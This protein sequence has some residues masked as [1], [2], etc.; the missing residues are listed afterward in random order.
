MADHTI[1]IQSEG[2]G[3]PD[4]K[5]SGDSLTFSESSKLLAEEIRNLLKEMQKADPKATYA[6]AQKQFHQDLRSSSDTRNARNAGRPDV[7]A[8]QTGRG[9]TEDYNLLPVEGGRPQSPEA[10]EALNY[11]ETELAP[12]SPF[13]HWDADAVSEREKL[14]AIQEAPSARQREEDISSDIYSIY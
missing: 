2:A 6:D 4:R 14:K 9:P 12:P 10:T 11:I 7:W 5:G 3:S 13:S 8:G 1:T